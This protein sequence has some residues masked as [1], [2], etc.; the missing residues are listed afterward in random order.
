[1]PAFE[2]AKTK[3]N[4]TLFKLNDK[5]DYECN[6]GFENRF[7]R[8][9]G[10][11][12]C[13]DNGWSHIPTCYE[14][15]CRIP[16]MGKF[17]MADPKKDKYKVGDL[18]KFSCRSGLTRVRPDSVQCYHFG[19]SPDIPTCKDHVVHLLHYSMGKLKKQRKKNMDTM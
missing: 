6:V 7:K 18:L 12:V 16:K 3:S 9:K 19:W 13:Q 15:E 2:N 1:M 8:A 17:L 11:I 10:S 5:L 4:A 14:R